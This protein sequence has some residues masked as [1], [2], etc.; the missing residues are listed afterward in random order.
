MTSASNASANQ[1]RADARCGAGTV[2]STPRSTV[3]VSWPHESEF[4]YVFHANGDTNREL[5]LTV[6]VFHVPK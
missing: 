1:I 3:M 6:L 5:I 4:R 2:L